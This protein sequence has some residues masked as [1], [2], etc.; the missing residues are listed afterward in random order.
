[1]K[2]TLQRFCLVCTS[3]LQKIHLCLLETIIQLL[4]DLYVPL[5][6]QNNESATNRIK[7]IGETTTFTLDFPALAAST[8]EGT[9][10]LSP[11]PKMLLGRMQHVRSPPVP[12]DLMTNASPSALVAQ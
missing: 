9:R 4:N 3:S 11:G 2:H 8:N 1:M 5:C 6:Y 10:S 12:L 7:S